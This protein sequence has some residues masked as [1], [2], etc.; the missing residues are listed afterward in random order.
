MSYGNCRGVR[1]TFVIINYAYITYL[2]LL[3]PILFFT[4]VLETRSLTTL[5]RQWRTLEWLRHPTEICPRFGHLPF[6]YS[7]GHTCSHTLS[8]T[9]TCCFISW[10]F[11]HVKDLIYSGTWV[12]GGLKVRLGARLGDHVE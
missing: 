12:P 5:A 1:I 7:N 2:L 4:S 10:V 3:F 8:H 9:C 11:Y 6:L